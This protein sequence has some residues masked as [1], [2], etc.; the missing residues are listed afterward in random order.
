MDR[1]DARLAS[2]EQ[3]HEE[4]LRQLAETET[5]ISTKRAE[6]DTARSLLARLR[7]EGRAEEDLNEFETSCQEAEA[8]LNEMV[9]H[10]EANRR[11]MEE[12]G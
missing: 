9:S 5:L 7:N 2:L 11:A 12:Q 1:T 4:A 8:S 3:K 6:T 10:L